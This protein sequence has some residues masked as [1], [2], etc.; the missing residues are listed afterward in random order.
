MKKLHRSPVFHSELKELSQ[1]S[2]V[3]ALKLALP[4]WKMLSFLPLTVLLDTFKVRC[5]SLKH[6]AFTQCS[7]ATS[8]VDTA[9]SLNHIIK[10]LNWFSQTTF[11]FTDINS[12]YL[13]VLFS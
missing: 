2:L 8:V 11:V 6:S 1:I 7:Y 9:L 5:L 3:V 13:Y 12:Y 4:F 10:S